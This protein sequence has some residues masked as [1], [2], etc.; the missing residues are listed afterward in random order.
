MLFELL[1]VF[2]IIIIIS[3]L[4]AIFSNIYV[5]VLFKNSNSNFNGVITINYLMVQIKYNLEKQLLKINLHLK[6]KTKT[7]KVIDIQKQDEADKSENSNT[8][9]KQQDAKDMEIK[10]LLKDILNAKVDIFEII[11][12]IPKIIKFDNAK[13]QLNLG[14]ADSELTTKVSAIIYS[15]GAVLYPAG[16]YIE[17]IPVYGEFKIKSGMNIKFNII[18]FNCLKLI[19]KIIRKSKLRK[20]IKKLISYAR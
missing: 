15:I 19:I 17:L 7:L 1:M 14:L 11:A 6:N 9:E 12:Y 13:I 8:D 18:I 5:D 2:L 16:L 20:L 4:I 10:Q 3:I